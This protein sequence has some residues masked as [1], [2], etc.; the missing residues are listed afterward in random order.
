M[1]R[2]DAHI[3]KNAAEV[4]L[5]PAET[6][7]ECKTLTRPQKC[8]QALGFGYVVLISY[9]VDRYEPEITALWWLAAETC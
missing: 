9:L 2:F 6:R 8:R 1:I 7:H 5:S 3:Q 4:D